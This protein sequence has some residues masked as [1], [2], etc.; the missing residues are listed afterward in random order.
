MEGVFKERLIKRRLCRIMNLKRKG[1][2][3]EEVGEV[4]RNSYFL[5]LSPI[6][7]RRTIQRDIERLP[8]P[9][10]QMCWLL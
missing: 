9:M 5:S 8:H 2:A 10:R 1:E 4:I 7:M 6:R 3:D